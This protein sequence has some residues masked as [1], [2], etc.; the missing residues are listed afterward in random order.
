VSV[1]KIWAASQSQR[2]KEKNPDKNQIKTKLFFTLDS[3]FHFFSF[4]FFFSFSFFFFFFLSTTMFNDRYQKHQIKS[5]NNATTTVA[6]EPNDCS[7]A[8]TQTHNF[9]HR[10]W[11]ST[12]QFWLGRLHPWRRF[13]PHPDGSQTSSA[14]APHTFALIS[15]P[16]AFPGI[17]PHSPLTLRESLVCHWS[18]SAT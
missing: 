6:A 17:A 11:C 15:S 1:E 8:C 13:P 12:R 5:I 4:L 3:L 14:T 7:P 9:R 10:Y 2:K 16:L 18:T